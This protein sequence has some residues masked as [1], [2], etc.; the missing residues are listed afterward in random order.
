M[1]A[2][3]QSVLSVDCFA[4]SSRSLQGKSR[5]AKSFEEQRQ[6]ETCARIEKLQSELLGSQKALAHAQQRHRDANQLLQRLGDA[7]ASLR[8]ELEEAREHIR[9]L[10]QHGAF[11]RFSMPVSAV[12]VEELEN[13]VAA[14]VAE[15]ARWRNRCQTLEAAAVERTSALSMSP[16]ATSL[17]AVHIAGGPGGGFDRAEVESLRHRIWTLDRELLQAK[18][19]VAACQADNR[20]C[21]EEMRA[22]QAASQA[23][24][25]ECTALCCVNKENSAPE[26][27]NVFRSMP[28]KPSL[29]AE[30]CIQCADYDTLVQRLACVN[31]ELASTP[32]PREHEHKLEA[33]LGELHHARCDAEASARSLA[34]AEFSLELEHKRGPAA[35]AAAASAVACAEAVAKGAEAEVS[36]LRAAAEVSHNSYAESKSVLTS[37]VASFRRALEIE[38]QESSKRAECAARSLEAALLDAEAT[39]RAET[40]QAAHAAQ[41][42]HQTQMAQTEQVA[43]TTYA[44]QAM[45]AVQAAKAAQA[46]Q[47]A[48]AAR[49]EDVLRSNL[50]EADQKLQV[51]AQAE[52][53]ARSQ[54]QTWKAATSESEDRLSCALMEVSQLRVDNTRLKLGG[55]F[56][57]AAKTLSQQNYGQRHQAELEACLEDVRAEARVASAESQ[58]RA[59]EQAEQLAALRDHCAALV[60]TE[61]HLSDLLFANQT[62]QVQAVAEARLELEN[63]LAGATAAAD[64][65]RSKCDA[66]ESYVAERET[67]LGD[68]LR[69]ASRWQ[70]RVRG[71]HID[72]QKLETEAESMAQEC[73]AAESQMKRGFAVASATSA[74]ELDDEQQ[75]AAVSLLRSREE[76]ATAQ[77]QLRSLHMQSQHDAHQMQRQLSELENARD[78]CE[79]HSRCYVE[80][81]Q[82]AA[83]N[84]ELQR[85]LAREE[86]AQLRQQVC[87][88]A[89]EVGSVHA[90]LREATGR[91]DD[92]EQQNSTLREECRALQNEMFDKITE[93][94][95]V[96]NR[97]THAQAR[98]AASETMVGNLHTELAQMRS[99]IEEFTAALAAEQ[100]EA[101]VL[102]CQIR[103]LNSKLGAKAVAE[104]HE[105][106]LAK[107]CAAVRSP[108]VKTPPGGP[109]DRAPAGRMQAARLG[110]LINLRLE[111]SGARGD[112]HSAARREPQMSAAPTSPEDGEATRRRSDP[113]R[114]SSGGDVTQRSHSGASR[115][116]LERSVRSMASDGVSVG[117][118][119]GEPLA[120]ELFSSECDWGAAGSARDLT[121]SLS[122]SSL[123]TL[124]MGDK[125]SASPSGTSSTLGRQSDLCASPDLRISAVIACASTSPSPAAMPSKGM[126]QLREDSSSP[127]LNLARGLRF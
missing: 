64:A 26:C 70:E 16:P 23:Q 3:H 119:Q 41:I 53:E 73:R 91:L 61:Q 54:A 85:R 97:L 28:E 8:A 9:A 89:D 79:S 113:P 51:L 33:A 114:C 118:S 45:Q 12:D 115:S 49:A 5:S 126:R 111:L 56:S 90:R 50:K 4:G 93:A 82:H 110:E 21:R 122:P 14:E 84:A 47:A 40:A 52:M 2:T 108:L 60:A 121:C 76:M 15:S 68:A 22:V 99:H 57:S 24:K 104:K 42:A 19:H 1:D 63:E 18:Q 29:I 102:R 44:T 65:W 7:N 100:S 34:S 48:Q 31:E 98:C 88:V 39:S 124:V 10:S 80:E 27:S 86:D 94:S 6:D 37:E 46:E 58:D 125:A 25:P 67:R 103:E 30:T 107:D 20:S 43:Q 101:S 123:T 74:R 77:S 13:R 116:G 59:S 81:L 72:R 105:I 96:S 95:H 117:T 66:Q 35:A 109:P 92:T 38:K 17:A 11:D 83:A 36:A 32:D 87:S 106:D 62:Q 75:R 127:V 55:A 69:D 71:L 112:A 120:S 78:K